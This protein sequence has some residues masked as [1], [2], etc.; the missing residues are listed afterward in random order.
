MAKTT[1]RIEG[2]KATEEQINEYLRAPYARILMPESDGTFTAE[3]LEFPGCLAQGDTAPEALSNLEAAARGWIAAALEQG[4]EIPAPTT[5][6]GFSGRVALR[7]PR[8]LHR[9][10]V[11]YAERDGT[12]LNQFLVTAVAARVGAEDVFDKIFQRY[13]KATP[14]VHQDVAFNNWTQVNVTATSIFTPV[15]HS[16]SQIVVPG[17]NAPLLTLV[18]GTYRA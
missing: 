7:L 17:H 6:Q 15:L 1:D 13:V 9:Q 14:V 5:N 8:G 3:I 4:Q 18:G 12:S 2:K 16:T 10:A 11:R